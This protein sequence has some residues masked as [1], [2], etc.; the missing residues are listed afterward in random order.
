M[1]SKTLVLLFSLLVTHL[2]TAQSGCTD[3]N[4]TNYN[5]NARTNDGSCQYNNTSVTANSSI[6]LSPIIKENSGLIEWNN[7]LYTHNDDTD[8]TLYEL[9]K[10]TGAINQQYPLNTIQNVDWEE[11]SQDANFIYIGDF[12]N[13]SSGNRTDLKIYKIN[14]NSL[15]TPSP[16]IEIINFTYSNQTDLTPKTSNNTDFDCE[17]FVVTATEIILFTKQWVGNKTSLYSLPKTAGNHV[18]NLLTTLN[19]DGL[20]TGATLKEDS[21]LIAL[22]GYNNL[23]QP[24]IY[25]I[26]DFQGTNFSVANKRKIAVSLEFHQIEGITTTDGLE[27]YISNEALKT[28]ISDT[29]QKIHQLSLTPYLSNYLSTLSKNT[30][31]LTTNTIVL[32]PNPCEN[33]IHLTNL[34]QTD[35]AYQIIDINGKQIKTG[36]LL[37]S[38][39]N[40]TDLDKGT[41][42]LKIKENQSVFKFIKK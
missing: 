41:Y 6:N 19:V 22:C 10:V 20:I 34:Q 35:Q 23:L 32:S 24:F 11:I 18:A 38:N 2:T 39:I 9:N 30:I 33:E 12:G 37:N 4:A 31:E 7:F 27:Y 17:A 26:Y 16:S 3:A 40:T 15:G 42:L 1:K 28:F 5:V 21:R 13:N 25:L 14:K 29:S 36:V 8:T